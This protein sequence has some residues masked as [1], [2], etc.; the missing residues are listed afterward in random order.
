MNFE[1]RL[2]FLLQKYDQFFQ[3]AKSKTNAHVPYGA[4]VVCAYLSIG[5]LV[6]ASV[7]ISASDSTP[8]LFY[9]QLACIATHYKGEILSP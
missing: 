1:F 8:F 5:F 3:S 4:W 2:L 9:S 7:A 6:V